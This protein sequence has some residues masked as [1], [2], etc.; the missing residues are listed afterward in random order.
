LELSGFFG[1]VHQQIRTSKDLVSRVLIRTF[2]TIGII[3]IFTVLF[4]SRFAPQKIWFH[5]F[6][7]GHSEQ[8][9]LS[10][11]LRFVHQQIR[12]SKDL[13]LRALIRTVGTIGIIWIFTDCSSADSY[14]KRFGSSGSYSDSGNNWNYLDFYGFFDRRIS[15]ISIIRIRCSLNP[16]PGISHLPEIHIKNLMNYSE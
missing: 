9:E 3:W 16:S 13:V 8:L 7:F 6:L 2:G 5:E 10:G 4:I 14:I 15:Q 12:T 1:F 11:F